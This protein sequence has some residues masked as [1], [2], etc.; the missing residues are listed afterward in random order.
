[1]D[2]QQYDRAC[3]IAATDQGLAP[4]ELAANVRKLE[5]D[6][7]GVRYG[8]EQTGGFTMVFA[9]YIGD[10]ASGSAVT[11]T[12]EGDRD[13]DE[14]LVVCQPTEQWLEG[15]GAPEDFEDWSLECK[16]PTAIIDRV[17]AHAQG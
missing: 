1:M 12:N 2:N 7:A 3:R 17:L 10:D 8:V 9:F 11:I 15:S 16:T 4:L 5:L 13:H 6:R 14:W